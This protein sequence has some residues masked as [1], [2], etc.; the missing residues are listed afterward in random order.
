M[1]ILDLKDNRCDCIYFYLN[2]MIYFVFLFFY[3]VEVNIFKYCKY[4]V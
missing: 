3:V 2:V 4:K 1:K